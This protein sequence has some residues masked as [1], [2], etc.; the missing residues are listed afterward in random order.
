[1]C[2][3][4][5]FVL[6]GHDA[7]GSFALVEQKYDMFVI[8]LGSIADSIASVF[9]TKGIRKLW[10]M[11]A[12]PTDRMPTLVPGELEKQ[13]IAELALAAQQLTAAGWLKPGGMEDENFWR[14]MS[15]LPKR[16]E[17][18]PQPGEPITDDNYLSHPDNVPQD[19]PGSTPNYTQ[20]SGPGKPSMAQKRLS[21]FRPIQKRRNW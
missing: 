21:A 1:M 5:D 14:T 17:A 7:V 19:V 15:G 13:D 18:P 4:A 16:T 11:N 20:N 12:F 3:L 9:N 10:E 6:I 2:I 8:S